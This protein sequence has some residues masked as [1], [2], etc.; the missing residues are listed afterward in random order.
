MR[1]HYRLYVYSSIRLFVSATNRRRIDDESTTN[2]RRIDDESTTNRR[3]I[4]DESM[5]N[6]RINESRVVV[7]AR[8]RDAVRMKILAGK[9]KKKKRKKNN[10]RT[11]K[12]QCFH[13][14]LRRVTRARSYKHEETRSLRAL[15]RIP[16]A[17]TSAHSCDLASSTCDQ[18]QININGCVPLVHAKRQVTAQEGTEE[19]KRGRGSN[20]SGKGRFETPRKTRGGPTQRE[21]NQ[22]ERSC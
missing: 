8:T 5:T 11:K 13:D 3:R 6:R 16:I 10:K 7:S 17:R 20:A 2:R 4:D 12:R 1:S 19:R 15:S 14:Y 18:T 9:E 21:G 22:E